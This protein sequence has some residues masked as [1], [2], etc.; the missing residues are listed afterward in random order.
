[1]ARQA[2]PLFFTGTID[3]IT[4][5]KME[6]QYLAR[7]KSS[8]NRKQFRTD[9]RFA[10]SRQSAEKFGEASKLASTIY[11]QL[12]KEQRGKGVVN[13]LTAQ[14]GQLLKEGKKVEEI[15]QYFIIHD[16]NPIT[17]TSIRFQSKEA[18]QK[19]E[20]VSAWK[21]TPNGNLIGPKPLKILSTMTK[22]IFPTSA[23]L[24]SY[25]VPLLE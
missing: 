7:K 2:G 24:N 14:V 6:G 25:L 22:N 5:Y 21:V 1:M 13:K 11:W 4:F 20:H 10:R 19:Q 8:L 15:I 16:Q 9:P 12:P 23:T 3:D 18:P 17:L